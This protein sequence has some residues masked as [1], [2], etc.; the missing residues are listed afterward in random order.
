M[1]ANNSK[2]WTVCLLEQ[3]YLCFL[4]LSMTQAQ[5]RV[6]FRLLCKIGFALF[7]NLLNMFINHFTFAHRPSSHAQEENI[8][9]RFSL[10]I[11]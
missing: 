8:L 6:V 4:A 7:Y 3:Q 5:K 11:Y 2:I 10:A 9:T 1:Y